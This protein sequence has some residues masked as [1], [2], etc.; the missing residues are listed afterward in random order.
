MGLSK[1]CFIISSQMEKKEKRIDEEKIS[2]IKYDSSTKVLEVQTNSQMI[3]LLRNLI[4]FSLSFESISNLM[5][6]LIYLII[7]LN[8]V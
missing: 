7:E 3:F 1:P 8:S 2:I 4:I 6:K 5:I